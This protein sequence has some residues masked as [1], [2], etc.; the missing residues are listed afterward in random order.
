MKA[1]E[2]KHQDETD[3]LNR[4]LKWY[5]ENQEILDKSAKQLK[6]KDDEIHKYKMRIEELQ[7]EV[8]ITL[9]YTSQYIQSDIS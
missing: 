5:A 8:V 1:L 9:L 6:K 3:K 4:K 7:T 2:A